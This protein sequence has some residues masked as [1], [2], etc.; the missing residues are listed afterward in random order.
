MSAL[1]DVSIRSLGLQGG[2]ITAAR[3][4]FDRRHV[5]DA[6]TLRRADDAAKVPGPVGARLEHWLPML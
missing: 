6:V 2:P 1:T 5:A 3:S 4:A